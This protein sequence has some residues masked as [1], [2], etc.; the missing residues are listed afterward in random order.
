MANNTQ[1]LSLS[2]YDPKNVKLYLGGERVFGFAADTKITVS[3]NTD[4]IMVLTGVDGE[5]SGALS[6]DRSGVMTI[7]LQNTSKFNETLSIWQRQADTTG[8]IWFPIL[9]EGSQGPS[10]S[11]VACIQRQPDLTYGSE[12]QQLDWELY[13]L[14]CWY[15]P[16]AASGIVGAVGS[17]FGVV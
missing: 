4:N 6:R 15:A 5:A 13:V 10:I 2:A 3:R 9:L 17:M 11:S 12:V 16:S 14:D 7:S 8:L 1:L